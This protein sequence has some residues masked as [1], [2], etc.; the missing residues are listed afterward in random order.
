MST[1]ERRR[2]RGITRR[3]LDHSMSHRLPKG[4]AEKLIIVSSSMKIYRLEA[5]LTTDVHTDLPSYVVDR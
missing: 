5:A 2:N 4:C 3:G 1:D